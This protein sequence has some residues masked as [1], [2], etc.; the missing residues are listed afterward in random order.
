MNLRKRAPW[1]IRSA[2]YNRGGVARLGRAITWRGGDIDQ[3]RLRDPVAT[4]RKNSYWSSQW[5]VAAT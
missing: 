2:R 1:A 3:A 4:L 5:D